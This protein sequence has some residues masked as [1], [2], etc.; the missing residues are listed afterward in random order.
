MFRWLLRQPRFSLFEKQ[1]LKLVEI[2]ET[3]FLGSKKGKPTA[4][5]N[6]RKGEIWPMILISY[7]LPNLLLESP[8]KNVPE[9]GREKRR[10]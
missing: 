6:L 1:G 5:I 2:G 7:H 10:K 3:D 4:L 9:I 8:H